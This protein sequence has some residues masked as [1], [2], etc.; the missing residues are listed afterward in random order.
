MQPSKKRKESIT[1]LPTAAR[2]PPNTAARTPQ[3]PVRDSSDIDAEME[4]DEIHVQ[5]DSLIMGQKC[6]LRDGDREVFA[7]T[8]VVDPEPALPKK[9]PE[10]ELG[11]YILVAGKKSKHSRQGGMTV[12]T[13]WDDFELFPKPNKN[14]QYED[15][16]GVLKPDFSFFKESM[17]PGK[18]AGM[19]LFLIQKGHVS[20]VI[21]PKLKK[22]H[23]KKKQKRT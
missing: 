15:W 14:A 22:K 11:D 21:D 18:L 2:A 13:T 7:Y 4:A 16:P 19:D 17:T 20:A 10:G 5:V 1:K 8:Y 6:S 3:Q 12:V 23:G 9:D